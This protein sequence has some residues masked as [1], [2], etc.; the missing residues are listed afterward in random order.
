[1]DFTELYKQSSNLCRFSPDG[2]FLA[3]AVQYRVVIRDAE[4][5]QI[6]HL[7]TCTDTVQFIEWSPDSELVCC[8]SFKLGAIQVWSVRNEDWT[9]KIEEGVAGCVGV[10]WTPDSR[11]LLSFSDYELRI[12]IW[13]LVT[14]E[15]CY[16]QY[17]K[18]VDRGHCF[19]KDGRYFALAERNDC[20][21]YIS[22]YDCE[23]W[24]LLKRFPTET[25]DLTDI[26]W[27]PDGQ[28]LAV[29]ETILDYKVCIYHPDGRLAASYSAYDSGLG[30]KSVSWSPSSQFLA[31]GSYDQKIRLLNHLTWNPI[32]QYSHF[33][34]LGE[35]V[36]IFV[37]RDTSVDEI[38]SA[39]WSQ[40]SSMPRIKYELVDSPHKVQEIRPDPDKP[41]PKLGIGFLAFNP[42]GQFLAARND[43]QPTTVW[44]H[45]LHPPSPRPVVIEHRSP[46]RQVKWNPV[47]PNRL[48][49]CCGNGVVYLAEVGVDGTACDAVEIPAVNFSVQSFSWSPDGRSLALMDKDKFC[50]AFPVDEDIYETTEDTG[51][52]RQLTD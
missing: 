37:E 1:M 27:S 11:H 5:L 30:I 17:P 8:A 31:I 25:A 21:D 43:N 24:S 22:V 35:G 46:V 38:P 50:L 47:M 42:T 23:D 26:A 36:T 4:T 48:A 9:A 16:I 7:F 49:I 29:W 18:Y 13:S 28:Y 20:K 19:R 6:L 32:L 14:K 15:A 33:K 10:R 34:E 40:Q 45:T 2:L 41:N 52:H 3:T 12:T 44:I 51:D 39:P